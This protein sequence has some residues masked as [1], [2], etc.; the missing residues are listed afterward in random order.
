MQKLGL[1]HYD[2][3]KRPKTLHGEN[4]FNYEH[5]VVENK[6]FSVDVA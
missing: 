6:Y 1:A 3:F 5:L 2:L 4:L